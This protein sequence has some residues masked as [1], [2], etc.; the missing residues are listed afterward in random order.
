[1]P[2]VVNERVGAPPR[3]KRAVPLELWVA[4]MLA[5]SSGLPPDPQ[6]YGFEWKWDGI[7]AMCRSDG[8]TLRLSGRQG[9]DI[10]AR[11]PELMP[12]A[13]A[14]GRHRVLLDGEIVAFDENG[15]PSFALLQRRMHVADA[16]TSARLA[17][18]I[19]ARF[20][21]F[22]LLHLDGRSLMDRPYRVRRAMLEEVFPYGSHWQITFAQEGDGNAMLEAAREHGLEG[23]VAKRLDSVYEPGRRSPAWIKIKVVRRQEFVVGGWIPEI[24]EREGRVGAMLIGYYDA[25][26]KLRYAGRVGTGLSVP[27]HAM[28]IPLLKSASA[29]SNPFADSV[30]SNGARFTRPE[31][32]IEVEYRRWP[33][34]AHVQQAAYKG[35]RRDKSPR[36]VV[37][38]P[39][40]G[41]ESEQ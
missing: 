2:R 25:D 15:L 37:K 17:K 31:L 14:L 26:G 11:Y 19:P 24:G 21:A 7:R 30:P 29:S 13:K 28:L 34:D 27:D 35:L 4:P 22:D 5:V 36:Q 32:V 6:Y 39:I 10:S 38:E 18:S 12:L 23:V 40:F 8:R 1:M 3:S 33:A 20:V 9:N 41:A 16:R